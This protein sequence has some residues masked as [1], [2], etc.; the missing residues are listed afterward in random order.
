MDDVCGGY[1]NIWGVGD[2]K[3]QILCNERGKNWNWLRY[4]EKRIKYSDQFTRK[5]IFR[6]IIIARALFQPLFINVILIRIIPA[7]AARASNTR[8]R[9]KYV[10][11]SGGGCAK[12][13]GHVWWMLNN[14][15]RAN[16][17][18]LP[19]FVFLWFCVCVFLLFSIVYWQ[20]HLWAINIRSNEYV[21]VRRRRLILK[22]EVASTS[23]IIYR[24]YYAEWC[25]MC[26]ITETLNAQ[27][28]DSS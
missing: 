5:F 23:T 24:L 20:Y 11:I 9:F 26:I 28:R 2:R 18:S 12:I 25:A 15:K 7:T 6:L 13:N 19:L 4:S 21:H 3:S 10:Q 1:E 17:L 16:R 14:N 8:S 27:T 22:E